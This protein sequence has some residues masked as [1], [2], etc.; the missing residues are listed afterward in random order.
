MSVPNLLLL[1]TSELGMCREDLLWVM[2]K[3]GSTTYE[4]D[5]SSAVVAMAVAGNSSSFNEESSVI[6]II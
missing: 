4:D 1:S 3:R 2:A 6:T 5:V